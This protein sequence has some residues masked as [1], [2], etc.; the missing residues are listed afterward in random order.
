MT[1][2]SSIS[3]V[4]RFLLL[5]F[6]AIPFASV[7]SQEILKRPLLFSDF[8]SNNDAEKFYGV[9][10]GF[11]ESL[12]ELATSSSIWKIWCAE[13]NAPYFSAPSA[14]SPKGNLRFKEALFVTKTSFQSSSAGG[15]HWLQVSRES[16]INKPVGWVRANSVIL[17][18]WALKTSG[19]VG[20][21]VIVVPGVGQGGITNS[22]FARMQLYN[23][24]KVRASD[25]ITGNLAQK[26]R[27]LYMLRETDKSYL[28]ASSPNLAG[29]NSKAAIVGWIPRENAFE[30]TRRVAYGPA[31][32]E[33]PNNAFVDKSIP[34]FDNRSD[35][36]TYMKEC[37]TSTSTNTLK[38]IEDELIPQVPAF[39]FIG[40]S[41]Y[42]STDPLR[43]ILTITGFSMEI[44]DDVINIQNR[45]RQLQDQLSNIHIYFIVDA[46]ASMRKYYPEIAQA[47]QS[48]NKDFNIISSDENISLEVGFGVYR[49][50]LDG[51][52]AVQT[53]PRQAYDDS[54]GDA[55]KSISC[56]SR[57]PKSSEAVYNGILK[58]LEQFDV[59]REASN[60]VI[61]I[62][63]EGN[64]SSDPQGLTAEMVRNKLVDLNA[65]LFV[66]QSTSYMTESS[67][68]FQKDALSW[69]EA[70]AKV[71]NSVVTQLE[72]GVIGLSTTS[73]YGTELDDKRHAKLI[74]PTE[75]S[76][77]PA[78]PQQMAALIQKDVNEWIRNVQK[79][80]EGL[81]GLASG[82]TF[83]SD[84]QRERYIEAIMKEA[85]CSR[86][87]AEKYINRGGDLARPE[88]VSVKRCD[89]PNDI[90]V[91]RPYV[92]LSQD[93]FNDITDSFNDLEH[94]GAEDK[95][96][97]ALETLC[98]DIIE[99]QVGSAHQRAKYKDK[100]MNE[101]WLE[102]FQVDFN[103][104]ELR[105][106]K[107]GEI[108]EVD[109]GFSQAYNAL[110]RAKKKWEKINI[111]QREWKA[112]KSNQSFYWVPAS[113]FPGFA[114]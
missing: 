104:P 62:G 24:Q 3:V 42:D 16:D 11:Q 101:I 10:S 85:K 112:A 43:E 39:P 74:T 83:D 57:N 98:N 108:K 45:I 79:T 56:Q 91:L 18:P 93:E 20:R 44:D 31:Y 99:S 12:Q 9:E 71:C 70:T 102:F 29:G 87:A 94:Q 26:F 75:G 7:Q 63:D 32:G 88:H 21:K 61:L 33:T 111:S 30:W 105:H 73:E 13:E 15:E 14:S 100:T 97:E 17:S 90:D 49:D 28:L 37:D 60:I 35:T 78:S 81:Q 82:L 66:F 106:V 113:K 84:E 96:R 107:L 50:Y 4:R 54:M 40:E 52:T 48:L 1:P 5:L 86:Q 69:I 77:I 110:M 72:P 80:L 19:G 41:S 59:D 58:S 22:E 2:N 38:I 109:V 68:R 67:N 76:G 92:F 103:I 46:T 114:N 53:F 23:H 51:P 55:I 8:L 25:A 95:Q 65:S 6:V 36:Q 89:Q 64:H 47:I 34:L 27:I